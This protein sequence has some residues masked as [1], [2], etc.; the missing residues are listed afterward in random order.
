MC[1]RTLNFC[2]HFFFVLTCVVKRNNVQ[3]KTVITFCTCVYASGE[4]NKNF[5]TKHIFRHKSVRTL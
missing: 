2:I 4:Q 5:N 1:A 3:I